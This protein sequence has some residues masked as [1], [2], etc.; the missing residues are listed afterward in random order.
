MKKDVAFSEILATRNT[1]V[2]LNKCNYFWE[3]AIIQT[4]SS[5][6]CPD[7]NALSCVIK[8]PCFY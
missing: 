1:Y 4:V 3:K 7:P 2:F 6:I 8:I 5:N